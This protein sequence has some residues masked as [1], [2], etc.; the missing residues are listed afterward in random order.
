MIR[1]ALMD[2]E[3]KRQRAKNLALLGVL[4]AVIALLYFITVAR[5]GMLQ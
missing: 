3:K 2:D 4:L 5:M 1:A